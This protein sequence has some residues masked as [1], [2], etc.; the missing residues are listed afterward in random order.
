MVKEQLGF[1]EAGLCFSLARRSASENEIKS[2][3]IGGQSRNPSQLQPS[4]MWSTNSDTVAVTQ[5]NPPTM[6]LSVALALI[7][8]VS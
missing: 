2:N 5:S 6:S 4:I 8:A 1:R 3:Q 7:Y